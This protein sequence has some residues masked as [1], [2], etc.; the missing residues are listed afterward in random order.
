MTRSQISRA[1]ICAR[2]LLSCASLL[3]AC[4]DV[5]DFPDPSLV[6]RPR[7]LAI[8][9]DPPEVHPGQDALISLLFAGAESYTVQW[10]ACGAFD[11]FGGSQYGDGEADE[12]C[13]GSLAID[14]G[15]GDT[16]VL[17]GALTQRFFDD[18]ELAAMVLGTALPEGTIERIRSSVGLPFLVEASIDTG[19]KQIRAVKRVLISERAQPHQN[20]PPPH[21]RV[22][23]IE[24]TAV[25]NAAFICEPRDG[26]TLS[27]RA[28]AEVEL[29]P[30]VD[31][32]IEPWVEPYQV[33][34]LR[35]QLRD[36][37]E[38]AFYSW[39]STA[40]ALQEGT[41]KSPL[42]NEIWHTP[43]APGCYP[44]W[45]VVRDGHGGTSACGVDVAIGGAD[46]GMGR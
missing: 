26:D 41:T 19:G 23:G 15:Q 9:A 42:R 34:D 14:L 38:T 20:P 1:G 16:A 3:A 24:V 32:E 17:P 44:L 36:R 31:G 22:G 27:V 29:A 35:G 21:F 33:I 2:V 4:A 10:R 18:L 46:C 43:S 30:V 40:G 12:G 11:S 45:L 39:F 7:V 13:G 5:P 37:E 8:V 25:P 6:D 28:D